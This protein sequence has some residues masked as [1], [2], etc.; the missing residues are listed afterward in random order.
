MFLICYH[1]PKKRILTM[2]M[3]EITLEDLFE[4][5]GS[6][7]IVKYHATIEQGIVFEIE[8]KF[9]RYQFND[10][11]TFWS[12]S[13]ALS[14]YNPLLKEDYKNLVDYHSEEINQ[15]SKGSFLASLI[16]KDKKEKIKYHQDRL[17]ELNRVYTTP[18]TDRCITDQNAVVTLYEPDTIVGDYLYIVDLRNKEDMNLETVYVDSL[19]P[20]FDDDKN[21]H[22]KINIR[23]FNVDKVE[24]NDLKFTDN[25]CS[26]VEGYHVFND[27][28]KAYD[29]SIEELMKSEYN[30][31]IK[32]RLKLAKKI[33]SLFGY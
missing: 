23:A 17:Q 18:A 11:N 26:P 32:M 29:F 2:Q 27:R 31:N 3:K 10:K 9:G 6:H 12:I 33:D 24:L 15:L 21:I 13:E 19:I 16:N 7:Y 5:Y 14:K 1:K 30:E 28:E 25:Y 4:T 8:K 22:I 20:F